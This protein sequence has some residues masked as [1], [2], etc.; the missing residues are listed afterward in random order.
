MMRWLVCTWSG[1]S[2]KRV[3]L[4]GGGLSVRQQIAAVKAAA[5]LHCIG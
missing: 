3:P 5:T 1:G 4:R 2:G